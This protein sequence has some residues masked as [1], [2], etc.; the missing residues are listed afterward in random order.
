MPQ[1]FHWSLPGRTLVFILSATS[2]WC[3]LA[4]FYGL[5][6]MNLFAFAILL[7]ATA[8]LIVVAIVDRQRGNRQLWDAV[9]IGAVSGLVAACAYDVFRLPFVV[10]AADNTGPDW[11]RLPLFKVFPRFGAAL[12]LVLIVVRRCVNEGAARGDGAGEH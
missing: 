12:G 4:E 8:A 7:P 3:L 5:C 9:V 6:P 10:A 1:I 2:I 11:L